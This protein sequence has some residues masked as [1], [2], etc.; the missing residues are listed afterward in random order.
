MDILNSGLCRT[1]NC[2]HKLSTSVDNIHVPQQHTIAAVPNR[3]GNSPLGRN[4]AILRGGIRHCQDLKKNYP[5]YETE[6][7]L[8][9]IIC[10]ETYR[11][12]S[13]LYNL[14]NQQTW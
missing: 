10:R 5:Q 2:V 8:E 9:L 11:T 7:I 1:D 13:F 4:S 3:G 14:M 6:T 12:N